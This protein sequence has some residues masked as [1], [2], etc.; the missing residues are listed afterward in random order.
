M[1]RAIMNCPKRYIVFNYN[2]Y[3]FVVG[4]YGPGSTNTGLNTAKEC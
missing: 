4:K 1:F 3:Y 2:E